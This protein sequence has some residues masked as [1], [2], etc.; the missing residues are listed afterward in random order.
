AIILA[1]ELVEEFPASDETDFDF[2]RKMAGS[3]IVGT[4]AATAVHGSAELIESHRNW[5]EQWLRAGA[6][7]RRDAVETQLTV[8]EAVLP[9]DAQV[10]ASWGLAALA[11]RGL[12]SDDIDGL[13]LALTVQRLHAVTEA[14][15]EGLDWGVRPGFV[16]SVYV[17]ALDSCV[18]EMGRWWK[19]ET[20]R[21]RAAERTAKLRAKA[22]KR[23]LKAERD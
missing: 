7:L 15:L 21:R 4:A 9:Y 5:I 20:E 16:Q 14:S 1:S 13:V 18:F 3:G 11:S 12:G 23:A 19:G 2:V 17:A 22:V 10:M 6:A 8:D